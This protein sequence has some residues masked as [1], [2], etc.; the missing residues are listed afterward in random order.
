MPHHDNRTLRHATVLRRLEV[1]ESVALTPHMR[2]IVLGGA[3]L[4]GF[5]SASPDDHVKLF[6]PNAEGELVLPTLTPEGPRFAEGALPSPARDYTPRRHDPAAGTLTVDFV[7]HGDG[8]AAA[9]AERARPGDAIAV[10]G[11]RASFV[12]ADD[13]DAYRI[14]GDETALPAIGRWL[15]ELPPG[16]RAQVFVEIPGDADRQDLASRGDV[17]ITWLPR[18]GAPAHAEGRL[19]QALRTAAPIAGDV[20]HWIAC[21]SRRARAMRKALEEAGV[22]GD[23]IRATGYWKHAA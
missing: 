3:E 5:H 14:L 20:F 16:R 18:D 7:L 1:R 17:A 10:G 11:P 23:W 21:E 4:E 6:L 9:W 12:V 22:P 8:P 15:E 2:R 19:E 13:F